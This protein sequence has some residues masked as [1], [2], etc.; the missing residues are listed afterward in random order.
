MSEG[1]G[2]VKL[3]RASFNNQLYFAEPFTKWQA[4]CDLLLLANHK[5][6]LFTVRGVV[7]KVKR[8]TIGHGVESIAK[9]WKWSRGKVE[10]FLCFLESQEVRQIV[11]QKNNVTTLISIINYE[12]YQSG[13]NAED[14]TNGTTSSK[15]NGH[16]QEGEEGKKNNTIV[17]PITEKFKKNGTDIIGGVDNTSGEDVWAK[18]IYGSGR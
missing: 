14:N 17:K 12:K 16:K 3:H 11:R 7:I 13:N 8:G 18:R 1:R 6:G 10:R 2:W 15:A 4:W 9:R 5:E